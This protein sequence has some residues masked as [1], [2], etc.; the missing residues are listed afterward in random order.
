[1][2]IRLNG[3]T[4]QI[5]AWRGKDV[6][7]FSPRASVPGGSIVHSQL[8]LYQP[9]Y[10]TSWIHGLGFQWYIDEGGYLNTVGAIDT[11]HDGIAMLMTSPVASDTANA[12][13]YGYVNFNGDL[14]SYGVGGGGI[15]GLR[16][17]VATDD[18][19]EDVANAAAAD[20]GTVNFAIASGTYLFIFPDGARV[21]KM[22]TSGTVSAAGVN[23]SSTDY[24]WAEIHRGYLYAGKDASNV[25]YFDS[26]EDLSALCGDPTDDTAEIYAGFTGDNTIGA[27]SWAGSLMIAKADGLYKLNDDNQTVERILSFHKNTSNFQFLAEYGGYLVF[28]VVDE[29]KV[30]NGRNLNDITPS[31]LTI[32]FPYTT[33]GL[34]KHGLNI[35]DKWLFVVART[36]E[37]TYEEHI[38]AWDG[39]GWHKMAEV[40][41]NGTDSITA[42]GYDSANNRIWYHL[43]ATADAT[44]YIQLQDQSEYPYANFPTG[45]GNALITSRIG[46]GFRWIK[47]STPIIVMETAN[48]NKTRYI[49]V[50]FQLDGSGT[51]VKWDDIKR[52]GVTTLRNPGG[53]LTREYNYIQFKFEIV[54]D[55]ATES[56]ILEGYTIKLLLRPE[57]AYGYSFDVP[58][59]SKA[60]SGMDEDWKTS[61][62]IKELIRDAR[63]SFS[64]I[65]LISPTGDEMLGYI[66]SYNENVVT[67]NPL[68]DD[69]EE[70]AEMVI[71]CNF[72]ELPELDLMVLG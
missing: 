12:V 27:K 23:A 49:T 63:A 25:I 21:E 26:N 54:T 34:F 4:L 33:Y 70:N 29:L 42:M 64:P 14:Y 46:A 62:E 1:M 51:W 11:R 65:S 43:D 15:S 72:L 32:D 50:Y 6:V 30:W 24:K 37:T 56:P 40:V 39:N 13:K 38:I 3:E 10:Q 9:I 7:D 20:Y 47:K 59:R 31:A 57:V 41:S 2:N 53:A 8:G 28:P 19:W 36:N 61:G 52:N 45:T 71:R 44:Y 16:K 66:T 48:C 55:T 22:N 35:D 5:S 69:G 60:I 68:P 18:A 67:L 58:A 17:Y